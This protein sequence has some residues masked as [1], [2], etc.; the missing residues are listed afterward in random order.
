MYARLKQMPGV[1][2]SGLVRD[3]GSIAF[4]HLY[5]TAK[6]KIYDDGEVRTFDARVE[7]Y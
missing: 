3:I 1:F 2:A 5:K 6:V 4:E 7:H